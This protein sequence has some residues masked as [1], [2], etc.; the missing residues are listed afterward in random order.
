LNFS[1]END[2]AVSDNDD[3]RSSRHRNRR[4]QELEYRIKKLAVSVNLRLN[5]IEEIMN[6]RS[7]KNFHADYSDLLDVEGFHFP[8]E[9]A[10][11]INKGQAAPEHWS[12]FNAQNTTRLP[13]NPQLQNQQQQPHQ[14][15]YSAPMNLTLENYSNQ[16]LF[17]RV[18]AFTMPSRLPSADPMSMA[19]MSLTSGAAAA[20]NRPVGPTGGDF[21]VSVIFE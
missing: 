21:E 14:I 4:N 10:K 7:D 5:T 13:F 15:N 20:A 17:S 1:K 19:S 3:S 12:R 8:D 18:P 11:R 2:N 16:E 9:L 6:L